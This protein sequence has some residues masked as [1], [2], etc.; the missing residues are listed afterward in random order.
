MAD[1]S[2]TEPTL[3]RDTSHSKSAAAVATPSLSRPP[4]PILKGS[5]ATS[6]RNGET[7][8]VVGFFRRLVAASIDA[9]VIVPAALVLSWIAGFIV[10]VHMPKSRLGMFAVDQWFDMFLRGEP[11][12]MM[13][14]VIILAVTLIYLLVFQIS[15]GRT[16]GMRAMKI[17]VINWYGETPT[18]AQCALR[19]VGYVAGIATCFLGFLW[20]GFDSEK[21]G[22]HDF[23]ARTYVVKAQAQ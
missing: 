1:T 23:I 9:A 11:A 3:L 17:K 19:T 2:D 20:M 18:P 6:K 5:P 13:K 10:N 15:V 8:Y 4:K 16:L 21:R 14:V 12:L 22:L 7:V